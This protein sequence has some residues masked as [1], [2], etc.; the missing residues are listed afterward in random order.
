MK[1]NRELLFCRHK[2]MISVASVLRHQLLSG[3]NLN[4]ICKGVIKL[5]TGL[6]NLDQKCKRGFTLIEVMLAI[7]IFAIGFMAVGAMQINSLN[8]TTK[9][10]NASEALMLGESQVERL[11]S[12]PFYADSNNIDDDGDGTTDNFDVIPDL[13][14]GN[15]IDNGDWTA[16]YMVRWRIDDDVPL[17]AYPANIYLPGQTLTRSKT[18]TVWVT[19][20][21][22][23]SKVLSRLVVAK[24]WSADL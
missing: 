4:W 12:L 15:H 22:N 10:R 1:I 21:R 11:M 23:A 18:I 2:M 19:P 13:A 14:A 7:G 9:S 8:S 5:K 17:A 20:D 24:V 6:R 3:T 16:D